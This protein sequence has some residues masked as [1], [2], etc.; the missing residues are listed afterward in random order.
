MSPDYNPSSIDAT[1]SR[2][3]QKLNDSLEV[4]K[5]HGDAIKKLWA[6]LGRIDVRVAMIS[7]TAT[8]VF[9]VVKYFVFK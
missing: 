5:E 7:A 1:L 8:G 9:L 6:A 4:Q 2:I 3:E